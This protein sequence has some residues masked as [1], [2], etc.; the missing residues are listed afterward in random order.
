MCVYTHTHREQERTVISLKVWDNYLSANCLCLLKWLLLWCMSNTYWRLAICRHNSKHFMLII[1]FN[2]S[3]S[4]ALHMRL[5][6]FC[7]FAH[8]FLLLVKLEGMR[9]VTHWR[10]AV[11][12]WGNCRVSWNGQWTI[13]PLSPKLPPKLYYFHIPLEYFPSVFLQPVLLIKEHFISPGTCPFLPPPS[14]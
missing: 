14:L 9:Q 7:F 2:I 6:S 12:L 5:F 1:S 11:C 10:S 4:F 3:A 13:G 8:F